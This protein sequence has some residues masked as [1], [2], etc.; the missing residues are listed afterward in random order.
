MYYAN[1]IFV[2]T[3]LIFSVAK[4]GMWSK[5]AKDVRAYKVAY[6]YLAELISSD[7][8]SNLANSQNTV[9]NEEKIGRRYTRFVNT[10][11]VVK[12]DFYG[13]HS[14]VKDDKM[15]LEIFNL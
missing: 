15:M 14:G 12:Q 5:Y 4:G 10:T 7:S 9:S 2:S 13:L 11:Y 3:Y 1:N 6:K 8:G